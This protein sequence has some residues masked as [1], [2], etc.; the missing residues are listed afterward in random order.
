MENVFRSV[1]FIYSQSV[2]F[3]KFCCSLF[4]NDSIYVFNDCLFILFEKSNR[5]QSLYEGLVSCKFFRSFTFIAVE[6]NFN[7]FN[8]FCACSREIVLYGILIGQFVQKFTNAFTY[9]LNFKRRSIFN[10]ML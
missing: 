2:N 3:V 8:I 4:L 5:T 7:I 6:Y 10:V 9:Y 1:I